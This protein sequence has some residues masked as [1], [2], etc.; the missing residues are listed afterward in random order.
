MSGGVSESNYDL[1]KNK[2]S[3]LDPDL[4]I[5]YE[6]WNDS[7]TIP[8]GETIRNWESTCELGNS[9]GFDTII[10][11][12]A[13]A[14]TGNRVMTVQEMTNSYKNFSYLQN[15]QQ[16]VDAFEELDDV[17]TKAADFRRIFDYVQEP[18]FW[19]GGHMT[20]FGNQIVAKN[21][22]SL[23]SPIYFDQKYSVTHNESGTGV[24]YAVA[25]IYLARISI[26]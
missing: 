24:V 11:V 21:V 18:V 4:I 8:T 10:L 26:T 19:D 7:N 5:I 12:Q 20:S 13:M 3:A 2:L 1:I 15:S 22:F 17:C 16:Y 23:I 25:Q 9:R 14:S 6:G